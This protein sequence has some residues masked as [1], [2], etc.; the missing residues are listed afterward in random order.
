MPDHS[1][2]RPSWEDAADWKDVTR[3]IIGAGVTSVGNSAF[4]NLYNAV[5]PLVSVYLPPTVESIGD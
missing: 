5:A 1:Q 4:D 3:V 2:A